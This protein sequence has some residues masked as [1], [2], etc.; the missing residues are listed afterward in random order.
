MANGFLENLFSGQPQTIFDKYA[1]T[2]SDLNSLR[3][4]RIA[5]ALG[6]IKLNYA[7]QMAQQAAD[8]GNADVSIEQN[9]AKY[10]PQMSSATLAGINLENQ[11]RQLRNAM[12]SEQFKYLPQQLQQGIALKAAQIEQIKQNMA[13]APQKLAQQ[14]SRFGASYNLSKIL[15]TMSPAAKAAFIASHPDQMNQVF[16]GA[17]NQASN[18]VGAPQ[19]PQINPAPSQGMNASPPMMPGQQNSQMSQS[20]PQS[21]PFATASQI[22]ANKSSVTNATTKRLESSLEIEKILNDPKYDALAQSAAKYAGIGGK[23]QGGLQAWQR[24]NPKD[25]ENALQFRNQFTSMITNLARQLEG[26]GVQEGTR[27]ELTGNL[28]K[29]FDQ[30]SSNPERAMDQYNRFKDQMTDLA[31]AASVAAQ[32]V[33]P[34]ARERAAGINMDKPRDP[35]E[36][37]RIVSADGKKRGSVPLSELIDATNNGWK[38]E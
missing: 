16:G 5:N 21:F 23:I 13:L 7:P 8:M 6:Q 22:A 18:S 38:R 33:Y 19:N 4:Q 28:T 32:P 20:S 11:G 24:N 30:M 15:G 31:R 2:A 1:S 25:Y 35:N 3:K 14:Q 12:S 27:N 29:S 34:G 10:A 37:V 17:L 9:K 26:L 36:M